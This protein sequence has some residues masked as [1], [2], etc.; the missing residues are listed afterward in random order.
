[1]EIRKATPED[2][3]ELLKL[4]LE[5]KESERKFNK[6]LPPVNKVKQHYKEYLSKDL[7]RE[8][9][10]VFVAVEEN[11]LIAMISARIYTALAI[12][13]SEKRGYLSNLF[14]KKEFR[15]KGIGTKLMQKAIAWLSSMNAKTAIAEIYKENTSSLKISYSLAFTDYSV[16]LCKK[17]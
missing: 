12:Y 9:S 6:N 15:K 13:D 4:K 10:A 7:S 8:N 16:K 11:Q 17:L 2:F 14:V 5:L 1:M 3:E